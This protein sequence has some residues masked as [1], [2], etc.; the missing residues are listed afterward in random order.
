MKKISATRITAIAIILFVILW[1]AKAWTVDCRVN[2]PKKN[3]QHY[4]LTL[5]G[6]SQY[7]KYHHSTGVFFAWCDTTE[8]QPYFRQPIV[9]DI[10]PKNNNSGGMELTICEKD[11]CYTMHYEG[12]VVR[13]R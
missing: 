2:E 6:H 12:C 3:L 5:Y 8:K 10:K 1:A 7:L 4:T 13:Y 9:L 11:N